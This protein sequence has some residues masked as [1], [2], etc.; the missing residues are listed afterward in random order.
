MWDVIELIPDHCLSFYFVNPDRLITITSLRFDVAECI[1]H[2]IFRKALLLTVL[3]IYIKRMFQ[4]KTEW[5]LTV[6]SAYM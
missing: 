1:F 6:C 5:Y 3:Y 4:E 2:V